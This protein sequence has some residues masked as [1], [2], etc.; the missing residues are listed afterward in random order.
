M[1][2]PHPPHLD[3]E[4]VT[5]TLV[6][7][8]DPSRERLA[9]LFVEYRPEL[10]LASSAVVGFEAV[11]RAADPEPVDADPAVGA[12]LVQR[13]AEDLGGWL[14][15]GM[16][17]QRVSVRLSE[18]QVASGVL[19]RQVVEALGVTGVPSSFLQLVVEESTLAAKGYIQR[20]LANYVELGC[21]LAVGPYGD[22]PAS[23]V[24]LRQAGVQIVEID[25]ELLAQVATSPDQRAV[26]A[27]IIDLAHALGM[28]V[29]ASE[30]TNAAQ[31]ELLHRRRCDFVR[32]DQLGA[33]MPA[34]AVLGWYHQRS[35]AS[36]RLSA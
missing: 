8:P 17:C 23:I 31:L 9:N 4:P 20:A 2:R 11:L 10:D 35:R 25:P 18:A 29:V 32:G 5:E 12:W 1:R 3:A 6:L 28:S 30:V 34:S 22:G 26:V 7:D 13:V 21:R 14:A 27:A 24:R 16:S 15:A 36:L 19:Q 33:A